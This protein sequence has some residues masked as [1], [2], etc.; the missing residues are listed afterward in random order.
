MRKIICDICGNEYKEDSRVLSGSFNLHK[1]NSVYPVR[2]KEIEYIF[3]FNTSNM[4]I[5]RGCLL[6]GLKQATFD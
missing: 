6:A 2:I 1:G 5:C 3:D 4:D